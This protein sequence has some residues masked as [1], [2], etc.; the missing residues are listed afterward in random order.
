MT[1][2]VP[3]LEV[4]F[5]FRTDKNTAVFVRLNRAGEYQRPPWSRSQHFE[6]GAVLFCV[7][8][9]LD[10]LD[11]TSSLHTDLLME[12][13][14]LMDGSALLYRSHRRHTC[15]SVASGSGMQG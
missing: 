5:V 7:G 4:W 9:G 14:V 13:L 2:R 10:V 11:I 1:S 6:P 15:S 3:A 8:V 12:H